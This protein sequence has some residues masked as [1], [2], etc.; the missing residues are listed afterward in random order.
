MRA[1][2]LLLAAFTAWMKMTSNLTQAT[3]SA[4]RLHCSRHANFF[5]AFKG[6]VA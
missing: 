4:S 6:L 2:A 5:D 3:P 1:R